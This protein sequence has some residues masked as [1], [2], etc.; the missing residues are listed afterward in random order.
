MAYAHDNMLSS[1]VSN[2]FRIYEVPKNTIAQL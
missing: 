2:L 1:E